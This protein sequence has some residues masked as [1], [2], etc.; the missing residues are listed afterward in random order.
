MRDFQATSASA[1][2]ANRPQYTKIIDVRSPSEFLEDCFPDAENQPVLND[3]QRVT[4]GTIN[5]EISAFEAKRVGAALVS[6]NIANILETHFTDL[7]RDAKLL[8]YCWRG[9]NRSASLATV[10]ARIGYHVEVIEGGYKAYRRE[11]MEQIER[12]ARSL[13]YQVIVGRTGSGKSLLLRALAMQGAQVLDLEDLARHKGSVLG[14]VPGDTQPSQKK[15][16]SLLLQALLAFRPDRAVFVESESRKIGQCQVPEALINKMRTSP[17]VDLQTSAATRIAL[18]KQDYPYFLEPNPTLHLKLEALVPL[19]G[20]D[21]IDAWK[22]KANAQDWDGFVQ[23]ML[24]QHYD[25]AYDR[26]IRRN[27]ALFEQALPIKLSGDQPAQLIEAAKAVL[28][29]LG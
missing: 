14:L 4:I 12:V 28:D 23:S 2:L 24:D 25:P 19:H 16:E 15:F 27:F 17:C 22:A 5:K 21:K 1:A 9:G 11:V 29:C 3:E 13:P 10:L 7:Q 8:V 18:L 26:S 20:R 6:R